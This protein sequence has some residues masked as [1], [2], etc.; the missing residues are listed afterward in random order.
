MVEAR[1]FTLGAGGIESLI[2]GT[3][4][5]PVIKEPGQWADISGDQVQMQQG[6]VPEMANADTELEASGP[7]TL[8]I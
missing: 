4:I 3:N 5:T 1:T 2:S 7:T 6:P 8:E